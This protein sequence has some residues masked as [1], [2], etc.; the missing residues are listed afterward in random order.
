METTSNEATKWYDKNW[1][2]I[3][4]CIFIFPVGLYGLWKSSAIP[5][6]WKIP[7]TAIILVYGFMLINIK[8]VV[9]SDESTSATITTENNIPPQP[10]LDS[11]QNNNSVTAPVRDTA[12]PQEHVD[13]KKLKVFQKRWADSIVRTENTP[14]N[15]FHLVTSKLSL[16]DTILFEY[17]ANTTKQGFEANFQQDMRMYNEWYSTAVKSKFGDKYLS[18]PVYISCIPNRKVVS[19]I[20]NSVE[21][22]HP[23]L[24]FSG[25]R[26]FKG[27]EFGKELIGRVSCVSKDRSKGFGDMYAEIVLVEGKKGTTRIPLYLFRKNYWTTKQE[28][29]ISKPVIKCN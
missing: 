2:V 12:K 16:P 23:A 18:Y 28:N 11:S 26:V 8:D 5:T 7:L 29:D 13:L 10:I 4:L 1:L 22:E 3:V 25:I 14:E 17:S 6:H 15:G 27:N 21:Y 9:P 24:A 20:D 19:K